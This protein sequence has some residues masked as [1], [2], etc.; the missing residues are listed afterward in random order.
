MRKFL[1]TL[2]ISSAPILCAQSPQTAP[3]A[4]PHPVD[5]NVYYRGRAVA[6]QFF[7]APPYTQTY[8]YNENLLRLSVDQVEHSQGVEYRHRV[9]QPIRKRQRSV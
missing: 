9:R 1:A 6:W 8:G 5:F 3:P 4:N 7:A 2:L